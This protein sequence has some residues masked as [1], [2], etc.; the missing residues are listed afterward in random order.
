MEVKRFRV[1]RA[2]TSEYPEPITFAKGAPLAVGERYVGPEGWNDWLFC[3]TPGQKGGWVP[4]QVIEITG[5]GTARAGE[6]YTAREL[7]VR[8]DEVVL[9]TRRLN[10]WI[11]CERA[12]GSASGWVPLANLDESDA[13]GPR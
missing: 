13:T 9:G 3:E 12:D 6:D 1:T 4:A 10:G 11:W 5:D 2:H 7:D 8:V